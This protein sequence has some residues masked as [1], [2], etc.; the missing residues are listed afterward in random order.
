MKRLF[1]RAYVDGA[2]KD[3]VLLTIDGNVI[4]DVGQTLD[5]PADAERVRG[6]IVPGFVDVHVH[7][8]DGADF[9]D[10][11]DE[12][13]ARILSFH[14]RQGT[15]TLAATT[16]SGSRSDLHAAVEA[17]RRAAFAGTRGAEIA[18]IHLEGPY[19][20]RERAGAQDTASI[21]GVDIQEL[22]A[23]IAEV[24]R[25]RWI[26]TV[27]PELE[28]VRGLIEHFRDRVL[29]SIGHTSA[30]YAEAVAA[31]SW[32]A[33]HFTHLF[34]AMT[35]MHHREPGVVGAAF[36]SPT[37]TVELI[38][39]GIHVHPAVL[40]VAVLTMAHRVVLITDAMRACGMPDGKYKLYDYEVTVGDGAARLANGTLAGSVLT[41]TRAVANMV[42]LAGLPLPTVLP[43]ATEIPARILGVADRKGKLESRF[44]ADL[45]VLGEKFEVERVFA[46]GNELLPV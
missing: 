20:N 32:G 13:N 27:A 10:G 39:D 34:N 46:R 4:A 25:M 14:A 12:A 33:S 37:A 17:I 45:V 21:R 42:E 9:M 19:I 31:L 6:C 7:G 22:A 3:D 30:D 5:V 26:V 36:E 40:R 38:A 43:L 15:T 11:N 1:G 41:M 16:L 24:P 8:A 28:G 29:F 18:G 2:I 23:L 35:G 44:D